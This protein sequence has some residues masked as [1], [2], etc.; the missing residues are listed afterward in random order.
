[1]TEP[2]DDE[3]EAARRKK[4]RAEGETDTGSGSAATGFVRAGGDGIARL[5]TAKTKEVWAAFRALDLNEVVA[6]VA[7]FFSEF[8][9]RASANLSVAWE[10]RFAVVNLAIKFGQDVAI[11]VRERTRES[12]VQVRKRYGIKINVRGNRMNVTSPNPHAG[13]T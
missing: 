1:M 11:A 8:P 10:G 2:T 9:T 12:A 6:A 7:E 13:L 4:K 3:I 5:S